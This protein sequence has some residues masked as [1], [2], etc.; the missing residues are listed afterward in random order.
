MKDREREGGGEVE[1]EGIR[2]WKKGIK[3][4]KLNQTKQIVGTPRVKEPMSLSI[5]ALYLRDIYVFIR[6][7]TIRT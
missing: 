6:M 5:L 4:R 2:G 1:I 7:G 3:D